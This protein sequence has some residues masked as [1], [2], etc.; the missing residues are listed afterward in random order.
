ME[1]ILPFGVSPHKYRRLAPR[2][3]YTF[4][5]GV[6]IKCRYL[7]NGQIFHSYFAI[8]CQTLTFKPSFPERQRVLLDSWSGFQYTAVKLEN[9]QKSQS[10]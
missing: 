7:Q 6:F 2:I 5:R 9:T 4:S 1:I 3:C 8:L 10:M